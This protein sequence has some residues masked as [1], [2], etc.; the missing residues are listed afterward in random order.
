MTTAGTSGV[1]S[2][3]ELAGLDT[4]STVGGTGQT[5]P[6]VRPAGISDRMEEC[7]PQ[8][9]WLG[10]LPTAAAWVARSGLDTG[11]S[12]YEEGAQAGLAV[13]APN[14][15]LSGLE[16]RVGARQTCLPVP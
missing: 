5:G 6:W 15:W 16:V 12:G 14:I 9:Q 11:S 3:E 13:R 4:R 8:A 2:L 10:D 1:K 7:F